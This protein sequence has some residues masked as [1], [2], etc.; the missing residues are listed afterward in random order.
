MVKL[1]NPREYYLKT[2]GYILALSLFL[3]FFVCYFY[4]ISYMYI[5]IVYLYNPS[6]TPKKFYMYIR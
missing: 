5:Y 6:D 3:L 2:E 4:V 1:C